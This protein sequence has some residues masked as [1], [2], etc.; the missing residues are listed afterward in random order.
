MVRRQRRAAPRRR[1]PH[2]GRGLKRYRPR[3]KG[4]KGQGVGAI[5][6]GLSLL[7]LLFK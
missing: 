1:R 6:A 4:M 5:M 7:P 2:K 3:M